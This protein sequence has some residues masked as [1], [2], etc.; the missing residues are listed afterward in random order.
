MLE[1]L[2][3]ERFKKLE[4]LRRADIDPYPAQTPLPIRGRIRGL[5]KQGGL[6][7]IDLEWQGGGI[8]AV[9][10]K[11]LLT[12]FELWMSNL[13]IGDFIA[14]RGEAFTTEAGEP[15]LAVK[16]I[17]LLTKSLRPLPDQWSGLKD[18]ETRL[19]RRYLDLLF[20]P[21][22]KELFVKKSRFWDEARRYLK[23]A[24]FL[25]VETPVLE[26]IPGGADTQP[27]ITHHNALDEDF[28]LR[29]S[30]ELPLKKLLVAGW[31]KVFEIGRIFRNEGIDAEHLQDY[32]QCEFYWAYADYEE[33]MM[34][35]EKFYQELIA[36]IFPGKNDRWHRPWPRVE[37]YEV[38]EKYTGIN[39]GKAAV[40][41]LMDKAKPFSP[42]ADWGRGRLIDLLYK[43]LVRGHLLEPCF[44]I[45]PP[46]AVEPLAKRRPENPEQVER[47]QVMALGTE[48]GK[49][50]SEANDPLDE[51]QR[52]LEQMRLRAAG[53]REAQELDEEFLTA[54]E[55]GMPPAAGFGFSERLFAVLAGRPVRET[56]IYPLLRKK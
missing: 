25:E 33:L 32:T 10:K 5:R 38:F 48:L 35:V 41:D 17:V 43:K 18:P 23:T 40:E 29:I 34:F 42:P 4:N 6:I 28:Y 16:Q 44:L 2:I 26:L 47:F 24:G 50:F 7:F 22:L 27:F 21:E 1:D 46:A 3:K 36:A 11:D 19:R 54:L 55:H 56:V 39:L 53:D 45:N 30:L 51:R 15:S 49:G 8:Q 14:V 37:Y 20:N 12:D 9:I 13:D 52:F 31:E